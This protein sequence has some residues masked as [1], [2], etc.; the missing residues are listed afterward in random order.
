M[1]RFRYLLPAV[2]IS[3]LANLASA[4]IMSHEVIRAIQ[5]KASMA[6]KGLDEVRQIA[7]EEYLKMTPPRLPQAT[8]PKDRDNIKVISWNIDTNS[9]RSEE[10]RDGKAFP[11]VRAH[12]RALHIMEELKR[13]IEA[14]NPDIIQLQEGR[15]FTTAT[16]EHVDSVTKTAKFLEH[17]GYKTLIKSYNPNGGDKAFKYITAFNEER[18][19]LVS[20]KSLFFNKALS[21]PTSR[22]ISTDAIKDNNFGALFERSAF[23][24][25]LDDKRLG[26]R[27]HVFNVHLD[28]ALSPRV[29][30]CRILM[31]YAKELVANDEDAK[32]IMTGD[33]NTIP[34][35]GDAE[36]LAMMR[37][38]KVFHHISGTDNLLKLSNDEEV[39]WSFIPF[40]YDLYGPK[41]PSK[42]E[43]DAL[44]TL[45]PKDRRA[46]IADYFSSTF[47]PGISGILDHV[48][49]RG[50][51][52][53]SFFLKPTPLF[54]DL[55]D[56]QTK[57]VV[58]Y[59][60][61]HIND[62]AAFASDHQILMAK[63]ILPPRRVNHYNLPYEGYEYH[64]WD[65][66]DGTEGGCE[67]PHPISSGYL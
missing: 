62:G 65:M 1:F 3:G 57:S 12:A 31:D 45:T 47:S 54:E 37:D 61:R 10:G 39:P 41:A 24:L 50:F 9:A 64:C 43:L 36:Q 2:I 35:W 55:K 46:K 56:Y 4:Q 63:L 7:F 22:D 49:A 42:E 58:S 25:T 28:L 66:S 11:W 13:V 6:T 17:M 33:F 59:I 34:G 20:E 27:F 5:A 67:G 52:N 14:E 26:R 16:G 21:V 18:F 38:P 48:F 30:A 44:D 23:I 40:P 32:I 29:N 15:D 8:T 19:T 51:K 53:A 60:L